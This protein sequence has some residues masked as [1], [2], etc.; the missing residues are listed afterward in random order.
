MLQLRKQ[1]KGSVNTDP[2]SATAIV[3]LEAQG[4]APSFAETSSR[5]LKLTVTPVPSI[6]EWHYAAGRRTYFFIDEIIVK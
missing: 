4:N 5:Y 1:V 6:P 3:T 2:A